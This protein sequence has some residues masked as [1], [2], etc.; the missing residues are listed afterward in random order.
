MLSAN[1]LRRYVTLPYDVSTCW[2]HRS[3]SSSH[4]TGT[5]VSSSQSHSVRVARGP[6]YVR[7]SSAGH[8][9][10]SAQW[11]RSRRPAPSA[12]CARGVASAHGEVDAGWQ[13]PWPLMAAAADGRPSTADWRGCQVG[14]GHHHR[15]LFRGHRDSY[16]RSVVE[17]DMYTYSPACSRRDHSGLSVSAQTAT[18]DAW[19]CHRHIPAD[20]SLPCRRRLG[21]RQAEDHTGWDCRRTHVA[22]TLYWGTSWHRCV[23][24]LRTTTHTK[25]SVNLYITCTPADIQYDSTEVVSLRCCW[26]TSA[27]STICQYYPV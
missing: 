11:R 15:E 18:S 14:K 19:Y 16:D 8:R 1:K 4:H 10:R 26:T 27:H 3:A 12:R 23:N 22:L 25:Q 13:A 2:R 5:K 6:W 9:R 17:C 24:N 20:R 21:R 7:S